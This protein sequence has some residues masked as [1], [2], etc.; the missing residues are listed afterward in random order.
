MAWLWAKQHSCHSRFAKE[1]RDKNT[2]CSPAALLRPSPSGTGGLSIA[3]RGMRLPTYSLRI[4][5]QSR[6][7]RDRLRVR[8]VT[9]SQGMPKPRLCILPQ[10][11]PLSQT[12]VRLLASFNPG[13]A[14]QGAAVGFG[15]LSR[16]PLEGRRACSC[17]LLESSR[18]RRFSSLPSL[19]CRP[20][21]CS[22]RAPFTAVSSTEK[23]LLFASLPS[24]D[25]LSTV[26]TT[27]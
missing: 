12:T 27:H 15:N 17:S 25:A 11:T 21:T 10:V 13:C 23:S 18:S 16:T 1:Q 3:I 14:K 20:L 4:H 2:S 9:P 7:R 6:L 8:S 24:R 19:T 22:C 26:E 5:C